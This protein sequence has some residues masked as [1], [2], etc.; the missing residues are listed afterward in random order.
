MDLQIKDKVAIVTGSAR[1]LGAATARRLAEEG[2]KVVVTD[3]LREQAE[4][5][6]A[7]LRDDGLQAHCI[8]ADIT[9][10]AE[11]QR[12]VD[13]AVAHFGGV[14]ILVNNAGFP[15]DRYLVK[16]SEDDWDLVMEVM[17][18]GAF[19]A[20]KAVMPRFI[21]QGWGRVINIS[22]RAHFGNPTQ[23]N[24]SA[25][26]AGLIG[27]AKALAI[28]EGRYGITVNCVAPGFM[29]TEMVQALATYETIKERAVAMQPI[30]RVGK[31][32]DIADAV[33]FLASERASFIT[34]EVLHVTGGRYG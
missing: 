18:K 19:L 20:S 28:E 2:A 31:P 25:A 9:K 32:A 6:A 17:L 12:L 22:S 29:E 5:T 27:M 26:K 21:E 24:Y 15:R 1:G 34:G 23:A 14:H 30:K 4:A 7:S 16:M 10:G 13:E 33:A 8:V 11:V 3:I